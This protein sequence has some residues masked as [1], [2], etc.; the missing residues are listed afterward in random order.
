ML[1][2]QQISEFAAQAMWLVLLLSLPA[3]LTAAV[4]ALL[5]AVAQTVT[6]IQ[7]QS[8]GQAVRQVTVLLVVFVTSPW[9]ASELTSFG[10]RLLSAIAQ[11]RLAP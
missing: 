6:Q 4:V 1:T 3:V 10:S 9:I 11:G 8:I 7:D 2:A 5:V